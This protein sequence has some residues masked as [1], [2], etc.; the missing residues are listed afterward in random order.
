MQAGMWVGYVT[1]GFISDRIGRKTAYVMYLLTAAVLL[2][3]YVSVR[4]PTL[5]LRARPVRRVRGD[6]ATSAASAR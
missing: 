3:V 1:F 6:R 4:N 5:L 2:A